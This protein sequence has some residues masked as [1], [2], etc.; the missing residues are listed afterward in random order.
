MKAI[1]NNDGVTCTTVNPLGEKPKYFTTENSDL[2]STTWI[3]LA[4]EWQQAEADRK[5]YEIECVCINHHTGE[6]RGEFCL[7]F[8]P[9]STYEI[10]VINN[11]ARIK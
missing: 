1:I 11:K 10:E 3:D 9:G 6:T 5:T 4:S 8:I 7:C 2:H